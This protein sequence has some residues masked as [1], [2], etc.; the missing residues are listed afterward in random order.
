MI[1]IKTNN[2]DL[3]MTI[4]SGQFFR[5]CKEYDGSY[6]I[7]LKDRIINVY[8]ERDYIIVDSNNYDN[9]ENIVKEFF[10]LSTDY[11]AFNTYFL[12]IDSKLENIIKYNKNFKILN[13]DPFETIISYIISQRNSVKNITNKV[14]MLSELYG[15][16]IKFKNKIYHLFPTPKQLSNT[17]LDELKSLGLGYREK[18]ILNIINDINSGKLDIKYI[19]KLN[20]K[21]GIEY[22]KQ[23]DGIGL[24]VASC[25][26]LFAYKKYDVFPIDTWIIKGTNEIYNIN[27]VESIKQYFEN[28]LSKYSGILLQYIFNYYRNNK[29]TVDKI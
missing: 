9:L 11:N 28:K 21:D 24:K 20:G 4:N 7:I 27:E 22:L 8:K 13:M 18:Y 26:L 1:K 12:S 2:F 5:Y 25:I 14:N 6:T 10:D 3:D 16:K 17:S 15:T 23:F 29:F 19:Y